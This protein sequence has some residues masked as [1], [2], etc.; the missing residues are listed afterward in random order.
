MKSYVC[1]KSAKAHFQLRL[2]AGFINVNPVCKTCFV[3]FVQ[4]LNM[5]T[6]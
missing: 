4:Y 5:T 2:K 3:G 6:K 1:L